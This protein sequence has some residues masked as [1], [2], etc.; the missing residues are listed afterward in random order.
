MPQL[1]ES[2]A[3]ATIIRIHVSAGEPVEAEQEIMEVETNKAVMAIT[4]PCTGTIAEIEADAGET[5]AV[6][7]V[8][9]HITSDSPLDEVFET[10]LAP[11][12]TQ[13]LR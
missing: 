2:I 3:E 4:A 8:L 9:G 7:T 6:G 10:P 11:G 13:L 1:G 5:Y 12:G